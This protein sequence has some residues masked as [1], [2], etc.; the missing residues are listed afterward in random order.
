M[1]DKEK[2]QKL[3]DDA[4]LLKEKKV[5][6][7]TPALKAWQTRVQAFLTEMFGED[8]VRTKNFKKRQF[9]SITLDSSSD[10]RKCCNAIETTILELQAYLY[11]E[12]EDAKT[13]QAMS[14]DI[15]KI[16]IIHGHDGELKESVARLIEKQGIQA[17]ILSEM[18]NTGKTIIEKFEENSDVGAAIALFTGDDVGGKADDKNPRPRARQNVIFEC[19][20]FMGKLGRDRVIILSEPN[21]EMPS[22]LDGVV[23][24][25]KEFWEIELLRDLNDMGFSIDLNL[26]L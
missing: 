18:T 9:Y 4:T 7:S 15:G 2:L 24:T 21:V 22:D 10:I 12:I 17:I 11:D 19:G 14:Y 13:E 1:T 8:D 3:I 25:N 5:N 23:W 20:Y 26:L 16:F 6:S